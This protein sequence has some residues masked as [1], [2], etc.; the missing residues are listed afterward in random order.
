MVLNTTSLIDKED[1]LKRKQ[2]RRLGLLFIAPS[3]LL[4]L[5]L[6]GYPMVYNLLISFNK[7]PVNP[8]KPMT[9]IGLS[10][11]TKALTDPKFFSA[12]GITILFTACVVLFSTALGLLIAV[13][14]NR[15]F[16]G[17]KVVKAVILLPY[18]VPAI[19]LIFAWKYMFNNT[20][21]IVNYLFVSVLH[22]AKQAPL[23]FDRP[24]SA[25]VLI[26]CFCVWKFTPYAFMSFYAILQTIDKT[27]YEAAEIDGANAWH[28]FWTITIPEIRPVLMTVVTLRTIWVFYMYTEVSL[29]S[30][31]VNTVS[32]YL[33]NSAFARQDFGKA[34]AIS[35]LLFVLVVTFILLV[36]KKVFQSE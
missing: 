34:A 24:I 11:Y 6:I 29:L 7:V 3:I 28:Q 8:S 16:Y 20:Y 4:V 21:G 30:S 33:Y 36:R 9:F 18:V 17:K 15:E 27:L 12:L 14:L 26:I 23:W 13:L 10:N 19:A 2:D 25:F 22:L 35:I 31:Q 1:V 5:L 32:V